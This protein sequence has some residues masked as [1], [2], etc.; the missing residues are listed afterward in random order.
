MKELKDFKLKINPFRTIPSINS[1]EIIWAGFHSIKERIENQILRIIKLRNSRLVLNWGEYGSGKTHSARYFSKNNV[2]AELAA[3]N[4]LPLSFDISF[5]KGKDPIKE[6]FNQIIDRVNFQVIREN[7]NSALD[8]PNAINGITD[9]LLINHLLAFIFDKRLNVSSDIIKSYLYGTIS[10]KEFSIFKENGVQRELSSDSDYTD[11]LA[12]LF[13]LISFEKKAFSCIILWID[14]FEDISILNTTGI[15]KINN[16]IR[17]LIDKAPNNLLVFLNLTQ[18]SMMDVTDLGDYL[19]EAV[20]SRIKDR[21]EFAFP[22]SIQLLEYL[23]ELLANPIVR[24]N[25]ADIANN[26]FYPF[27]QDVVDA[28]LQKFQT[29][30]LRKYNLIFSNLLELALCDL[31]DCNEITL[32]FYNQNL[33]EIAPI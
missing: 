14:E 26:K 32:D 5:P 29:V 1:N 20:R 31:D 6:I 4:S 24:D 9:S 16:F 23:E 15:T 17:T 13:S 33:E 21:V 22:D 10:K 2:L 7:L 25:D 28:I 3:A 27:N 11:F 8:I 12:G 18:S 19:S 30:S